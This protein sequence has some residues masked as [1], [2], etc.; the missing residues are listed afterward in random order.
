[1]H[2]WFEE[3]TILYAAHVVWRGDYPLDSTRGL[4]RKLSSIQHTWFEGETVL[5]ISRVV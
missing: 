3:E 2:P 4:K 5:Y 1:M